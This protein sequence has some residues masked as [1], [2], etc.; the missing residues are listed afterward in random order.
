MRVN[1]KYLYIFIVLFLIEVYIGAFIHDNIIR[2][3]IGDVLV[4]CLIYFFIGVFTK[5]VSPIYVFIF[6]CLIEIG[7]YFNLVSLLH[8]EDFKI[9]KIIIGSTFDFC[10]IISYLIGTILIFIY[11]AIEKRNCRN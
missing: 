4:V 1:Y 9:A 5:K 6:S 11:K 7:Q 10:D 3:F 2:P 8:M